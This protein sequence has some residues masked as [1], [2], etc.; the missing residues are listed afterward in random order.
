[1][2]LLLF[3]VALFVFMTG[4]SLETTRGIA[5][6]DYDTNAVSPCVGQGYDYFDS[7]S[8]QCKYCPSNQIPDKT[9]VDGIGNY[10]RCKCKNGYEKIS[11]SCSG[12]SFLASNFDSDAGVF[13]F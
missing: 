5:L 10:V 6:S 11:H 2:L 9:I 3:L 7:S 1:M 8:F 4:D 12:V 13:V